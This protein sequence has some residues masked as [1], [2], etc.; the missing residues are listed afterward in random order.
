MPP[1]FKFTKDEI[2]K[3]ALN[4]TKESGASGLTARALAARLD[5]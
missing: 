1:R 3:A 5:C 2:T 4:I